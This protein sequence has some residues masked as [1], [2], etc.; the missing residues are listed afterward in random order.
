VENLM[1]QEKNCP[2]CGCKEIVQARLDNNAKLYPLDAL[3]K[4]MNGSEV[5]AEVCTKCGYIL[6]MRALKP[7][8]FKL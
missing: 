8:K 6:N 7:E 1:E 2:E 4:I 5:I 3:F